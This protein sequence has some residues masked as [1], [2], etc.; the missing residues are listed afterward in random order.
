MAHTYSMSYAL[1]VYSAGA[2]GKV[3]VLD[4][5]ANATTL[6]YTN[7]VANL[8]LTESPICVVSS[9]ATVMNANVTAPIGY[10]GQ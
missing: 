4:V 6:P 3:S 9:S 5:M 8:K 1:T 2:N 7:G 10:T